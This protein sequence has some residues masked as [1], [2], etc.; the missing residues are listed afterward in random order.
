MEQRKGFSRDLRSCSL[1]C[2]DWAVRSRL[3]LFQ[4]VNVHLR[5]REDIEALLQ[6]TNGQARIPRLTEIIHK[7]DIWQDPASPSWIHLPCLLKSDRAI[8][9][10]PCHP[11]Q[12]NSVCVKLHIHGGGS[13]DALYKPLHESFMRSLPSSLSGSPYTELRIDRVSLRTISEL[14]KIARGAHRLRSIEFNYMSWNFVKDPAFLSNM[15]AIIPIHG[16][17][18]QP[19]KVIAR[20]STNDVLASLFTYF[21]VLATRCSSRKN[22]GIKSVPVEGTDQGILRTLLAEIL[23]YEDCV[24][25]L[26]QYHGCTCE[27]IHRASN[28]FQYLT[29]CSLL[30]V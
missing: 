27:P 10:Q 7:L 18:Y 13:R 28:P 1:V 22:P 26:C 16:F 2:V 21:T 19:L 20:A 25:E 17:V 9:F 5:T 12:D 14:G 15:C 24:V 29:F 4:Q 6:F 11:Q 8:I 30:F 23:R 3:R